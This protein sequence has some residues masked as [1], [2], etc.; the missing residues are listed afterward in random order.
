MLAFGEAPQAWALTRRMV[1]AAGV[2]LPAAVREGWLTRSD[3]AGLVARCQA[4]AAGTDCATWVPQRRR[5]VAEFCPNGD[6]I[7]Q[8]APAG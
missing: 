8:M 1:Q 2:D 3:L 6:E 4:C 5:A 7:S